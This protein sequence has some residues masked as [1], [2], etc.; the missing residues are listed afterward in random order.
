MSFDINSYFPNF[1]LYS[2][3]G[4]CVSIPIC[5]ETTY[6]YIYNHPCETSWIKQLDIR[7][8]GNRTPEQQ[9]RLYR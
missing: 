1:T 3:T 4:Q 9:Y 6:Y 2:K 7:L 8:Q 5:I